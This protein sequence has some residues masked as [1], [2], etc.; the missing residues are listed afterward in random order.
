MFE[1]SDPEKR[2]LLEK[3]AIVRVR[4]VTVDDAPAIHAILKHNLEHSPDVTLD[5]APS[6]SSMR[7][8]IRSTTTAEA[9]A[10]E[11]RKIVYSVAHSSSSSSTNVAPA[12]K[13]DAGTILGYVLVT[14]YAQSKNRSPY[15]RTASVALVTPGGDALGAE[16]DAEVRAAL[17]GHA[18]D[19][20]R[21]RGGDP[22]ATVVAEVLLT[23]TTTTTTTTTATTDKGEQRSPAALESSSS[24][25][26]VDVFVRAGF[27]RVGTLERVADR[28][29]VLLDKVVLQKHLEFGETGG[30]GGG[31]SEKLIADDD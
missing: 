3:P 5:V 13:N 16:L 20:L 1:V 30:G 24:S 7:A 12:K 19:V 21:A 6:E 28:D 10:A 8:T 29:G 23:T 14:P 26:G 4:P 17:L 25:R 11:R 9:P 31:G 22:Y 18:L 27:R 2:A 15:D